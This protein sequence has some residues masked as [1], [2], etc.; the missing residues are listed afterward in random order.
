MKAL[1]TLAYV[2]IGAS[3]A[4][5]LATFVSCAPAIVTGEQI[6]AAFGEPHITHSYSVD[7]RVIAEYWHCVTSDQSTRD[8]LLVH[9]TIRAYIFH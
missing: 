4:V 3:L 9:D 8:F 5:M 2:L 1:R 6:R 7:G